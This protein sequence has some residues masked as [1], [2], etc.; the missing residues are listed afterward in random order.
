MQPITI[1]SPDDLVL[2]E[3]TIPGRI[4]HRAID[5]SWLRLKLESDRG[6]FAWRV[7]N[8]GDVP[9]VPGRGPEPPVRTSLPSWEQLHPTPPSSAAQLFR[10]RA[11][12]VA[13]KG[14]QMM[15]LFRLGS[16]TLRLEFVLVED[17]PA[18]DQIAPTLRNIAYGAHDRQMIDAYL[19][20]SQ[21]PTPAVIYIHGGAWIKGDKQGIKGQKEFVDAGIAVIAIN[22]RYCP[23]ENPGPNTP[24]VAFPLRD[25]AR[26]LQFVRSQSSRLNIDSSNIGIWGVSAGAFSALWLATHPDLRDVASIDPVERESSKPNY[27]AAVMAQTSLD[28][29]EMQRWVGPELDYGAHAFAIK[30]N[31]K[32]SRFETFLAIRDT[33][34]P[35]IESYSP[36]A[37]L[38]HETVPIYLDY[39]DFSLVPSEPLDSYFVHSPRFGIGFAEK[40]AR[41]GVECHLR[42]AGVED[43]HYDGWKT[44]LIEKL[45]P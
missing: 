6:D 15:G 33:L 43:P 32:R 11:T 27:I 42:Y 45:S 17:N 5:G 1:K 29:E 30:G 22:Y 26:A 12:E 34:M 38:D 18:E 28:P 31:G 10:G 41:A 14:R 7:T 21:R 13:R 23:D 2:G 37:L 9:S 4:I 39:I 19:P 20:E 35:W 3:I 36:S 16:K 44:F 40:A 24:A 8:L 25:A